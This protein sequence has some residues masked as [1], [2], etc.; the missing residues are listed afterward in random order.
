MKPFTHTIRRLLASSALLAAA[1][2]PIAA[3]S[4]LSTT[5][6]YAYSANAGWIDLRPSA[7][8]G[9]RV[10]DTFLSGFAYAANFGYLSLGTISGPANGH[11]FSNT[12]AGDY[13]VNISPSGLLTGYAYAPNIGYIQFEQSL[14]QPKINL[15]TGV[16][17][18]H[19]YSA[20]IGWIALATPQSTLATTTISRPDTDLDGIPDDWEKL[21]F[22]TL[23]TANATTDKDGD[24][25]SDLAEY[26]AGTDPTS[27]TSQLRITAHTYN[28]AHTQATLTWTTVPTRLYRLEYDSD[29]QA[30]WTPSALG[31]ISP[32]AGPTTQRTLNALTATP[33]RFFRAVA[34]QPLP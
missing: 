13:G 22:G 34:V 12:S 15:L 26:N 6:R 11:T 27:A 16:F 23:A 24:G 5:D 7:G 33:R 19:A 25:S 14:G 21:Y 17:T 30:P 32:N 3:Q 29:L 20:N 31:T 9:V 4:T 10:A 18:G 2:L 28:P 1:T 8:D